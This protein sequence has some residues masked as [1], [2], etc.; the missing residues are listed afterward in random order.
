MPTRRIFISHSTRG[1]PG[2]AVLWAAADALAR[3]GYDVILDRQNLIT[4]DDWYQT[5]SEYMMAAHGAVLLL[6]ADAE[7]S[8]Y[9]QHEASVLSHRWRTEQGRFKLIV[10]LVDPTRTF[11][12]EKLSEGNLIGTHLSDA[13]VW[14]GP[15]DRL[16]DSARLAEVLAAK[17]VD[18]FGPASFNLTRWDRLIS[19]VEKCL[20]RIDADEL[21]TAVEIA[22]VDELRP[23]F[24]TLNE[25]D[26][27]KAI[28]S[29][30][31]DH[32]AHD[33]DTV[34][35][36]VEYVKDSLIG[37]RTKFLKAI[38]AAEAHWLSANR[39]FCPIGSAIEKEGVG[40]AAAVNGNYVK[41]YTLTC[42]V[43]RALEPELD[44]KLIPCDRSALDEDSIAHT[45]KTFLSVPLA[46]E[47]LAARMTDAQVREQCR[48]TRTV[49]LLPEYPKGTAD[50]LITSLRTRFPNIVFVAWPG[51]SMQGDDLPAAI[52]PIDPLVDVNLESKRLASWINVVSL[53]P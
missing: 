52:T 31:V 10:A 45:I 44:F 17:A 42:L 4:G 3:D 41:D 50:D 28:A 20:A 35:R 1:Q 26:R 40:A 43:R 2:H 33:L 23:F 24:R 8:R 22:G 5:I 27:G 21:E 12:A 29:W 30:M 39:Q 51:E 53:F 16:N 32:A 36:L 13:H 37:E 14:Q 11:T 15:A 9:V 19:R 46:S 7:K 18:V 6:N 48:T 47:T 38:A 25:R 49:C 34:R